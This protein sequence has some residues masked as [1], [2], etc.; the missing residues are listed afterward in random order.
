MIRTPN[1]YVGTSGWSYPWKGLFYPEDLK[2]ADYLAYYATRFNC[3]EVNSSFYHFTMAKTV[4]K[5]MATT[6]DYFRYAVKM[7]REITHNRNFVDTE[8][9]VEKFMARFLPMGERLGPVLIQIAAS[10]R[11]NPTVAAKFFTMLREKYPDQAFAFEP[12]HASWFGEEPLELLREHRIAWVIAS[13]GKRF[14]G[15]ELAPSDLVY[16]RLHGE[17]QLYNSS[18]SDDKL[19]QYAFMIKDWLSD[20]REVWVFFNN[21]MRGQAVG[22]A[23]RLLEM[24]RNL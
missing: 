24:I 19:E 21:T 6:P 8:E 2:S 5:W 17:E 9:L 12:R 4:E 20:G 3:T 18:Y 7:N 10:F 15:L 22:D 14:P 11:Y 16:F 1:L 13:A 23:E